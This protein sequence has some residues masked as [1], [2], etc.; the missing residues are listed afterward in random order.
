MNRTTQ[1]GDRS[2]ALT[3]IDR[4]GQMEEL[5]QSRDVIC[6]HVYDDKGYSEFLFHKN[7]ENIANFIGDRPDVH[8]IVLTDDQECPIL[9]TIG[10]FIDRCPDK[11]RLEEV[12]KILIPIQMG[13]KEAQPIFCP[14]IGE[15]VAYQLR[16]TNGGASV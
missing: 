13:E 1:N 5:L 11:V 15:V 12:K 14:S 3:G 7:P 4:A 9:W 16:M 8:Q 10:F 6:A 2:N